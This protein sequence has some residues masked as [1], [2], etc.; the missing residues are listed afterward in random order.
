MS[1]RS[2][3][4]LLLLELFGWGRGQH[5]I[6]WVGRSQRV[7]HGGREML[8]GDYM[9]RDLRVILLTEFLFICSEGFFKVRFN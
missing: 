6:E 7:I 3:R 9:N 8:D 1:E 5:C 2:A 4:F